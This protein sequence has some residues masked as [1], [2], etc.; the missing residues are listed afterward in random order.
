MESQL[1]LKEAEDS[2]P[3]SPPV[4]PAHRGHT[5]ATITISEVHCSR[6]AQLQGL[7]PPRLPLPP[8]IPQHPNPGL[9]G[10]Y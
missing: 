9:P 3:P 7:A 8:G 2:E 5:Q 6:L 4:A 1:K 10:A